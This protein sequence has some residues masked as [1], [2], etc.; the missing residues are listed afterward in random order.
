MSWFKTTV[1]SK[2][3]ATGAKRYLYTFVRFVKPYG[4]KYIEQVNKQIILMYVEYLDNIRTHDGR[5]YS[6][7]ETNS[8]LF[9]LKN[10]WKYLLDYDYVSKDMTKL[11]KLKKIHRKVPRIATENEVKIFLQSIE[12]YDQFGK[13]D[14]SIAELFY[15]TGI[16]RSELIK[17]NLYDI[18]MNN[19]TL[20]IIQGKGRKD[21]IVPIG[22][23]ALKYLLIYLTEAR[24]NFFHADKE[25]AIYLSRKGGRISLTGIDELMKRCNGRINLG[26]EIMPHSCATHLLQNGA[27][28]RYI[29]ELLGHKYISTTEIY[30]HVMIA[31]L[32][33]V[34]H[35]YHPRDKLKLKS[36]F[37]TE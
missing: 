19:A 23:Y 32:H 33:K 15:S 27:D 34:H 2:P 5:I 18:D 26:I 6:N 28:I 30:T 31:D 37:L 9:R 16:R 14:R 21:R 17:L 22:E 20:R 1:S 8:F 24:E 3:Y 7:K 36:F 11:L 4:I 13:R 29:Q 25:R 12:P 10:F 35:K